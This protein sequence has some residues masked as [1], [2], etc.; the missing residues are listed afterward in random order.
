VY[1]IFLEKNAK[2]SSDSF[3]WRS[4]FYSERAYYVSA[5]CFT[6][7]V[8]WTLKF[9]HE[10]SH[11][12]LDIYEKYVYPGKKS[13]HHSLKELVCFFAEWK[14][15]YKL[16]IFSPLNH[17]RFFMREIMNFLAKKCPHLDARLKDQIAKIWKKLTSENTRGV[18][19]M[20]YLLEIAYSILGGLQLD[21]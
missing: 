11:V 14:M 13:I 16:N 15:G 1:P 5:I 12:V 2:I 18:Y 6:D 20:D 8:E 4:L 7:V 3:T 21:S 9:I 19:D 10:L 17:K